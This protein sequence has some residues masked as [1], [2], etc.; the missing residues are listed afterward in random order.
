LH[1]REL[2]RVQAQVLKV[3][4]GGGAGEMVVA[5]DAEQLVVYG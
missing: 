4:A 2:R 3:A 1:E 5:I